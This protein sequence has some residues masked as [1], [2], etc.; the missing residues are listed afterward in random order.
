MLKVKHTYEVVNKSE[1]IAKGLGLDE[2]NTELAKLIA[3]LHDIMEDKNVSKEEL[4]MISLGESLFKDI[5]IVN[6]EEKDRILY[7]FI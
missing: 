7:E 6:P 4:L 1:Y 3:L 2:E 5:E